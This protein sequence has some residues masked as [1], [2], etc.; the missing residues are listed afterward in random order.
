[1][2]SIPNSYKPKGAEYKESKIAPKDMANNGHHPNY[3]G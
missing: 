1:V 3:K 2:D